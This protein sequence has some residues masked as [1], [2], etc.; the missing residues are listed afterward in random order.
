MK[1][2]EIHNGMVW[3]NRRYDLGLM[4]IPKCMS[5]TLKNQFGLT[6]L[7]HITN[8]PES[9]INNKKIISI[10]RDPLIRYVSGYLESMISTSDYPKGRY[11]MIP[12][13][14][15]L[16]GKLNNLFMVK[17]EIVKFKKFTDYI[18]EYGYFEPHIVQQVDYIRDLKTKSFYKNINIFKLEH[19]TNL[20]NF[21]GHKLKTLNISEHQLL[22]KSLIQFIRTDNEYKEKIENLYNEDIN[23]YKSFNEKTIT[24]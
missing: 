8:L 12:L 3:H 2:Y 5:T 11:H 23:F 4:G 9:M 14:D 7:G 10:V 18:F 20:E 17:D 24:K 6:K 22:K 16:K 15:G 13:P 19:I 1:I 21:L